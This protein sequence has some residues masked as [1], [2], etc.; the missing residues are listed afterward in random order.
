MKRSALF[1]MTACA[2]MAA[3]MC[4]L[5]PVS[6]PIGPIPI[7]L[8]ILVILIT[9]VILGTWRALV[10][11]TVYLLL[12]AV[13]MP[14]FSGFQGGLAKLAGP[15]GGYL[16]AYPLM[17]LLTALLIQ[18]FG[19]GKTVVT[20][21]AMLAGLALCYLGGS[22]WLAVSTGR[23]LI[24]ALMAGVVPFIA[25]DIAKAVLATVVARALPRSVV[26]MA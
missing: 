15:T 19:Q 8:S 21:A 25:A 17:A 24:E 7:S 9:V 18:R 22:L 5:C 11:Y 6:I 23:T 20:I 12:G 4:V 26:Q 2:L 1:N 13:G 10:S 14:V 3:L 16:L